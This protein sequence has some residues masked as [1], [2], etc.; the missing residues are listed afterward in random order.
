L[1]YPGANYKH[2]VDLAYSFQF[3]WQIK[4]LIIAGEIKNV[5]SLNNKWIKIGEGGTWGPSNLSDKQN[6]Q[7]V[8]SIQYRF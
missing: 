3:R 4:K 6:V 5:S 1:P 7:S 8:L 2:Y